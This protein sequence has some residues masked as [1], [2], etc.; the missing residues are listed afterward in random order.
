[1]PEPGLIT[2]RFPRGINRFWGWLSLKNMNTKIREKR[3]EVKSKPY[4]N[5]YQNCQR[6]LILT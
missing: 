3:V 5:I 4:G 2:P 6:I 1:M